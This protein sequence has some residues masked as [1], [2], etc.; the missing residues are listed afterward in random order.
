[1]V[2]IFIIIIFNLLILYLDNLSNQ[3]SK[4]TTLNQEIDYSQQISIIEDQQNAIN[5]I[6]LQLSH[7]NDF[8]SLI[9]LDTNNNNPT[10]G[11]LIFNKYL[12][13]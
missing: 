2:W 1:M 8:S 3:L 6:D 12:F 13:L 5:D 11:I 7:N 9:T 10:Q 4:N